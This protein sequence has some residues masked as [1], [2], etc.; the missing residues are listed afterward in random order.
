MPGESSSRRK[1]Q[2]EEKRISVTWMASSWRW[3]AFCLSVFRSILRK[4]AALFT[5]TFSETKMQWFQS[6]IVLLAPFQALIY[7]KRTF[8]VFLQSDSWNF[9]EQYICNIVFVFVLIC[10]HTFPW[11]VGTQ[12]TCA[13]LMNDEPTGKYSVRFVFCRKEVL[14]LSWC[15]RK[16]CENLLQKKV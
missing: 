10:F 2:L 1:K 6:Q 11:C 7:W 3:V 13:I 14:F 12:R 16:W 15:T 5:C 9:N 8:D 4:K